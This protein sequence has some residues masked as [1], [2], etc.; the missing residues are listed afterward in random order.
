MYGYQGLD[1]ELDLAT[2]KFDP[3]NCHEG[4]ISATW[5]AKCRSKTKVL[6]LDA[7]HNSVGIAAG[8]CA[9]AAG[10]TS[11][12]QEAAEQF[13]QQPVVWITPARMRGRPSGRSPRKQRSV[14]TCLLIQAL[15]G[16]ADL[17][18]DGRADLEELYRFVSKNAPRT[19]GLLLR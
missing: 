1:G 3:V 5:L 14:F 15:A 2:E 7:C 16:Q 11:S 4:S 19:A 9:L 6:F 12:S 8:T 17:D 10:L 18:A 13:Q